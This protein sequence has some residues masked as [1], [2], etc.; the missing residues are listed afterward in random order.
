MQCRVC[1]WTKLFDILNEGGPPFLERLGPNYFG[2]QW[3]QRKKMFRSLR[4]RHGGLCTGAGFVAKIWNLAL[5]RARVVPYPRS[6]PPERSK[7]E[8]KNQFCINGI[9]IGQLESQV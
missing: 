8:R 2:F 6:L 4:G 1:S 3:S 7:W 5:R 9:L